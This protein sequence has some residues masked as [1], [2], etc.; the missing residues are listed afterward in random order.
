MIESDTVVLVRSEIDDEDL[1]FNAKSSCN[2]P[3]SMYRLRV[4]VI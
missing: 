3:T 4:G 2:L 1:K